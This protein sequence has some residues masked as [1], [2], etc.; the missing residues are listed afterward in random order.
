MRGDV[1]VEACLIGDL[2][3]AIGQFEQAAFFAALRDHEPNTPPGFAREPS[4]E[5]FGIGRRKRNRN[6]NFRSCG[7]LGVELL[8]CRLQHVAFERLGRLIRRDRALRS[9]GREIR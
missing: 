2:R 4:F 9:A 6:V 7:A 3:I 5:Q 8:Q 1:F